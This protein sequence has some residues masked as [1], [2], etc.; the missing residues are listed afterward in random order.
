M[1][2]SNEND[3]FAQYFTVMNILKTAV[4]KQNNDKKCKIELST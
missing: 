3:C 2:E 4:R 1:D